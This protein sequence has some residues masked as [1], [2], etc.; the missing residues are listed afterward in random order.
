MEKELLAK[1]LTCL[2]RGRK[3][4]S[5]IDL[6]ITKK[7]I[8]AL[9]EIIDHVNAPLMIMV[10]GEF[11][12]GK[13][14]FINAMVGKEVAA[15]NAT[16]TTAVITKLC[17]GPEDKICV[18]RIDGKEEEYETDSF[19]ELTAKTGVTGED[20]THASIEY[21]ERQ[22]PLD[23]LNYV[24][25]IDSPG[26]N[27]INE[28]HSDTT[29]KFVHN[30]DTVFWMFSALQTGSKTEIAAM[31]SLSPRLKPIAIVNKMDEI[32]EEEDDP[33]EFL[34]NIR[35]QLKDKVQAVV[36]ISAKYALEGKLENNEDKIEIGN[37]KE[38]EQVVRSLVL[39]NRDKFKINS[40]MDE[41]GEWVDL[42]ASDIK[43]TREINQ[44]NQD[45]DYDEYL[46]LK[47]KLQHSE[48]ALAGIVGSIK[49]YIVDES[50]K[51]NE[52]AMYLLGVLY[53]QGV[54]F[55]EDDKLAEQYLEAAAIKNHSLAQTSLGAMYYYKNAFKKAKLWLEKAVSQNNKLA[56]SLLG[57]IY[58]TDEKT[59]KLDIQSSKTEKALPLLEKAAILGED[60]AQYFLYNLF[61]NDSVV[62]KDTERAYGY[63]M[64]SA[65]NG[66]ED[67]L[68]S[69][70]KLFAGSF[71][72]E[73]D[74]ED[75]IKSIEC[76]SEAA[77]FGSAEAIFNLG[78]IYRKYWANDDRWEKSF[79]WYKRAALL[80]SAEAQYW[81]AKY[82]ENGSG[83]EKDAEQAFIW[84]QKS[85]EQDYVDAQ[86]GLAICYRDGIGVEKNINQTCYWIE[87]A[88]KLGHVDAQTW[89]ARYYQDNK[90]FGKAFSWYLKAAKQGNVDAQN[91]VAR[92]F[93]EG[94]GVDKDDFAAFD[95]YKKAAEQGNAAAAYNLAVCYQDGNGITKDIVQA[96]TWYEKAAEQGLADAQ[97]MV[98]RYY[99]E[100]LGTPVDAYRA[101]SWYKKAA[102]QGNAYGENKLGNCYSSGFGTQPDANEAFKWW[103]KASEKKL[104]DAECNLA[105]CY[106]EGLGVEKDVFKAFDL[107]K[108]I[109]EKGDVE[110]QN[111]L[112]EYYRNGFGV[113]ETEKI[114]DWQKEQAFTWFKKAA[115]QGLADA[116]YNLARCY[117]DGYGVKK[118]VERAILWY[119]KAANQGLAKAQFG[120]S[121]C[122]AKK[123]DAD[124]MD[125]NKC[126][127]SLKKAAKQGDTGAQHYFNICN[128]EDISVSTAVYLFWK[129]LNLTDE[130]AQKNLAN[131]DEK[132]KE[133]RENKGLKK[134]DY[135]PGCGFLIGFFVWTAPVAIAGD[136]I[137]GKKMTIVGLTF[138]VIWILL[139]FY[140]VYKLNCN[141]NEEN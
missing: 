110:A 104:T 61:I 133:E 32:D 34:D 64:Q 119:E 14:T 116:Q 6:E 80:G 79:Q 35:I 117:E 63:L 44:R 49:E 62:G 71:E 17:Y 109:A 66:N 59:G 124:L 36:G 58:L 89:L 7:A 40:L 130:E 129:E 46:D 77:K 106:Q 78:E 115:E 75:I 20:T 138:F 56:F 140:I 84:Y 21:V 137:F 121:I 100:G 4:L 33:E 95:W 19:K 128:R 42:F 93:G 87:K 53:D 134:K 91:M 92:C 98:G 23:I 123:K 45:A 54:V 127:Y 39:P 141:D 37:F 102:E 51:F 139:Y 5:E 83:V 18:H 103:Q 65:E 57:L 107:F 88:G 31:E 10:M 105:Y 131:L 8:P 69:L 72:E 16:P 85:A 26:L 52:Q 73:G 101:F 82:Y 97:F 135:S 41:L 2:E 60:H 94:W 38:L 29:K 1:T 114:T 86:I 125:I 122:C 108:K 48:E 27:D 99:E 113:N 81:I 28:Q 25:I 118:N 74:K 30:S 47:V 13:S 50:K 111:I 96:L 68:V 112:G 120:I 67:A 76:F 136:K 90:E 12:T 70:G 43:E 132:T 9:D 55:A 15:V 3:E 24:T 11:S 22:M 126:F